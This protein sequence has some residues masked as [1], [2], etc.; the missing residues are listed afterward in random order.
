MGKTRQEIFSTTRLGTDGRL[1]I[2]MGYRR[3]LAVSADTAI[4]LVQVGDALMIVP[5]DDAL[6]AVTQRLETKMQD[7]GSDVDD[8]LAAA[9]EARAEIVQEEFGELTKG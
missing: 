4:V 6:T 9:A 3:A 8:L 5:C 1:T 2:P 7:P